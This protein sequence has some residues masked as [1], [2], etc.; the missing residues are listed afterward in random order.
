MQRSTLVK[1]FL[2]VVVVLCL[3]SCGG[4]S[5]SPGTA[6]VENTVA[7]ETVAVDVDQQLFVG[8]TLSVT[9]IASSLESRPAVGNSSLSVPSAG[10]NDGRLVFGTDASGRIV[11]MAPI[12]SGR[13]TLNA[14]TTA[15]T[16]VRL[17]ISGLEPAP[18]A[19][20]LETKLLSMSE[21]AVL[22]SAVAAAIKGGEYPQIND[23][24]ISA[25]EKVVP[26]L[27][28]TLSTTAQVPSEIKLFAVA[29]PRIAASTFQP[30]LVSAPLGRVN[31]DAIDQF[32]VTATNGTPLLWQL[33]NVSISGARGTLTD[34][35]G[36]TLFWAPNA[37]IPSKRVERAGP[38]PFNI[39]VNF[40]KKENAKLLAERVIKGATVFVGQNCAEQVFKVVVGSTEYIALAEDPTNEAIK[41]FS[42]EIKGKEG[43]S[44]A[45]KCLGG[46]FW[47][48]VSE[49]IGIINVPDKANTLFT[50]PSHIEMYTRFSSFTPTDYGVCTDEQGNHIDCVEE[51]KISEDVPTLAREAT[52]QLKLNAYD[53]KGRPL[54]AY[55]P[56]G[57][58][59][60]SNDTQGAIVTYDQ[61]RR[62]LTAQNK[63]GLVFAKLTDPATSKSVGFSVKVD[64]PKFAKESMTLSVG[65]TLPLAVVD[66]FGQPIL[67]AKGSTAQAVDTTIASW[68]LG[69]VAGN[70]S[71]TTSIVLAVPGEPKAASAAVTVTDD[72]HY[73]EATY[74]IV[75][76][77]QPPNARPWFWENPCASYLPSS[78][79]LFPVAGF[80]FDDVSDTVILQNSSLSGV[81]A[82]RSARS[83]GWKSTNDHWAVVEP[84][85]IR[86]QA[87]NGDGK[88]TLVPIAES[89]S[90]SMV[91]AVTSRTSSTLSGSFSLSTLSGYF[92]FPT[93]YAQDW[94]TSSTSATGNW[95]AIKKRGKLPA[96]EMRGFQ[97]C[98]SDNGGLNQMTGGPSEGC[99]GYLKPSWCMAPVVNG[100]LFGKQ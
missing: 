17:A 69:L 81:P 35:P 67:L 38:E 98:Q 18:T 21:F 45:T 46:V 84:V 29:I 32:F 5:S 99:G 3:V 27:A 71:G 88:G 13:T 93:Q 25:L 51:L 80:L 65:E 52:Y 16:L 59:F 53:A 72:D 90:R 15:V 22:E 42:Q 49:V 70:R 10:G 56:Y 87:S 73:W 7:V 44:V 11:L 97:F 68:L 9:Q 57:L 24:V 95:S 43:F 20:T 77:S 12:S 61:T 47:K 94:K 100:C 41:K 8:S 83:L 62:T 91:F 64:K 39:Q 78:H 14:H 89:A 92:E 2:A 37:L 33:T 60:E 1:R 66:S 82:L 76:C 26:I 85:A 48:L 4:G 23:G 31:V 96:I 63:T 79:P 55:F 50:L 30:D 86:L 75:N 36:A 6:P 40:P 54:L 58:A 19:D 74:S 34:L 28:S